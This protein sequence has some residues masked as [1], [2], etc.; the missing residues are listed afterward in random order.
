[1]V[2][3]SQSS[4]HEPSIGP[5]STRLALTFRALIEHVSQNVVVA[6][7]VHVMDANMSN[8][9]QLLESPLCHYKLSF[10]IKRTVVSCPA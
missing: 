1:M 7:F 6:I 10:E 4:D 8:A 2:G 3:S 5:T 9:S